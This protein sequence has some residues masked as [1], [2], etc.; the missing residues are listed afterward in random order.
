MNSTKPEKDPQKN[1]LHILLI[2][3]T[4][5]A[6]ILISLYCLVSGSFIVFQNLFYIPIILSC[7]YYAMRGFIYSICL[8]II[9]FFLILT[10]T[11]DSNI[12]LQA[13]IRVALFIAIGGIITFLS[14]Q[15]KRLEKALQ[16]EREKFRTVADFTYDWVYWTDPQRNL[17][18]VSPSC[19]RISG[20][21]SEEFMADAGL[22][23][24]IVHP[25]DQ[26]LFRRHA[27]ECHNLMAN[28]TGKV[29]FRI[30]N[31][32]SKEHWIAHLCQPVY[33]SEGQFLGRC[34]SNRDITEQKHAETLI[35]ESEE[36]Y[37]MAIEHSND[38]VALVEGDYHIYVN[39]KFLDIFGYEK[40]EDILGK[41]PYM[42]LHPD[43]RE[44][45]LEYNRKRQRGE[46]VPSKY[47]FK[48]IR[49]DG[50]TLF[51][52]VSVAKITY[53]GKPV[54][55]AY[56]RDITDRKKAE[57]AL[58]ESEE[59]FRTI[60]DR[61]GDGIL[62][63]DPITK[64]FLQ[65]NAAICSMLGYT[66][67]EIKN[68]T[69]YD[70]H[71]PEDISHILDEFEKQL[72]GE[73]VLAEDLPV[74]RKDGSIFY[75]DIDST[76]TTIG[77]MRYLMGIFRDITDRKQ[78]EEML[79]NERKKFLTLS[80]NAPFGMVLIDTKENFIY[81]NPKFK[82]L[83]GYDIEDI[84]DG[85]TWFKKA[86][87]DPEYRK[88]VISTWVED[89][90]QAK[91]GQKIPRIFKVNCKDGTEKIVNFIPVQLETGE[92]I[93]SC[94]DITEQKRLEEQLHTMSLTDELTGLYNR[95]GFFTLAQ[96]QMK[97]TER[98][99]KDMLLFFV[100]LD[101]MKQINDTLGHQE[102][103][104][105][106]VEIATIL[107][108]VFRESDIIG[109]MGGDEFAILAID[110]TD[111]TREVLMKRL[112]NY[113]DDYNK[114]EGRNYTLSLSMGIAHYEPEKPSTLD[115][116]IA[117]ADTLMYEEKKR[118]HLLL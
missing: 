50:T 107:K 63:A 40:P 92:H 27:D 72:K 13:L 87:P 64:K 61:A 82:E 71:P 110:T 117:Q 20:Y 11:S 24:H 68:L 41:S 22:I 101:R 26:D 31:R 16:E 66:K 65:G 48:G 3:A 17:I 100:D 28:E 97:V 90:K 86:Y 18:Y 19:E 76:P 36:R 105:A 70:I 91:E 12:I 43:D 39:Q 47:E 96:Q 94:D 62:L 5:I 29:E 69:V 83:F 9:Y 95:R 7:V 77:G 45:V 112:H 32:S 4:A 23:Y 109:R 74:L 98:T 93:I 57:E 60:F 14:V 30:V 103:D 52:E 1:R 108:E 111:E 78:A 53:N 114:P 99:K 42:V 6:T 10:F 35:Q 49:K 113:L 51:V 67:E 54:S 38:G 118:K 21:R 79:L 115:E 75:A 85:R 46:P 88:T 73:K 102:G 59:K 44:M 25:D 56:L 106:L 37:R 55:L 33:N 80:E 89:L 58:C 116:L 34:S 8:A 2:A 15:R 104:K 84:P 81:I